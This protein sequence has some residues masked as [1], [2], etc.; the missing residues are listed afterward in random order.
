MLRLGPNPLGEG[1]CPFWGIGIGDPNNFRSLESRQLVAGT[2]TIRGPWTSKN[3][4]AS[5]PLGEAAAKREQ[6]RGN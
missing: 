5:M 1:C 3:K 2:S 6:R 4:P